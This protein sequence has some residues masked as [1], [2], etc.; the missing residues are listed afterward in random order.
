MSVVGIIVLVIA[1]AFLARWAKSSNKANGGPPTP[2]GWGSVEYHLGGMGGEPRIARIGNLPVEYEGGG[3]G[4]VARITKIG[5]MLV[6][7]AGGLGADAY[8]TRIGNLP[9]EYHI[10]A[11]GSASRIAKIGDMPVVYGAA[12]IDGVAPI[13]YIGTR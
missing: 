4:G 1:L 11:L 9:V 3:M 7:Y 6:E 12:G 2:R 13:E 5:D 8:I 10:G